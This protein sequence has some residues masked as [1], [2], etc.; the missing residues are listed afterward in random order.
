M[1]KKTRTAY[2]DHKTGRFVSKAVWKRSRARGGDRYKRERISAQKPKKPARL[3]ISK[4]RPAA[5]PEV[6]EFVVSFSYDKSGRSFDLIVTATD[7]KT[8][9]STAKEFLSHDKKGQNISRAGYQ[10]WKQRVAKGNPSDEEP[11][12]AEYRDESE[13]E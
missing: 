2:R 10:G 3:P 11:G 4:P 8:A 7:Q 9:I 5:E 6:F 12:E 1:A 13:E